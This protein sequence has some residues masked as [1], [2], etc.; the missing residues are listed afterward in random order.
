[1][2]RSKK[3][4]NA[5]RGGMIVG[6][7]SMNR[8]GFGFVAAPEGDI[9]VGARDT[10]GAM[11]GDTVGIKLGAKAGKQGRS[12]T[13]IKVLE[14]ANETI[15]GRFERS[16][17]LGIVV[18]SDQRIRHDVFIPHGSSADAK[19]GDIVVVRFTTYPTRNN[20]AQGVVEEILGREGD[21]G[22]EIEIIIREHGLRTEFPPEVT[23]AAE[24]IKLDAEEAL[25]D[26]AREDIRDWFTITVDPTDARDFDDAITCERTDDGGYRLGVHIADVSHYVPW[27]GVIDNEARQRATSVYLVDRVLPM[28]PEH[29]SNNICSLNPDEDRLSFS[30]VM[31]LD[32]DAV[33]RSYRLFQSVM[34]SNRRFDYGQV[35]RYIEGDE[36]FPDA[37]SERCLSQFARVA[38]LIGKRRVARGGLDFESVEAKLLL[39]E[40]GKPLEVI[41]RERTVATNMI[42]EAMILANEV[43]AGHMAAAKAPMVY[44]IHE[45]PD[46]DALGQVAVILKEFDYPIQD[47]HGA[48][49]TTFQK[50]IKFAHNRP[51]RLLINSLMLRAMQR[52][53]YTDFLAP[54]FGLASEA[55]CHFT[56]PIRRYPDLL[57]HRLLAAQLAG[58]LDR[59]PTSAMATEL[60]WL[61]DH[62]SVM[63][64]E[65]ES[66]E[67]DSVRIK[68]AELMAEH[69]GE[70]FEGIITG[71]HSFGLFLQL[72][73]T[74]EG[75]VHVRS[76]RDD[77]YEYDAERFMLVGADRG[78][79]Y[80]L[81]GRLKVRILNVSVAEGRIDLEIV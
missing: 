30:V 18:P 64:R 8:K 75:L 59:L 1:M 52:A 3:I 67:N 33:V 45:D 68:L 44:R 54:H 12:G 17:R 58:T 38:A 78:H 7:I 62:C 71:V 48:T 47:I 63:E 40:E 72:D 27:D 76:L 57:V 55:Y 69:I 22:I 70:E 66:A 61:A 36:P 21:P 14:R 5:T 81:G 35:Q 24:A 13:V 50:I 31:D 23:Q 32:H 73:N 16:G 49:P 4:A 77:T 20:A 10:Q 37:D 42:E 15:V 2:S 79:M 39:S 25:R 46:A 28:L 41:L 29:L 34:R 53:R 6:R 65:A 60:E 11:H 9:Y 19:T 43:V 74:A 26:P 56:S 51:E 80:R